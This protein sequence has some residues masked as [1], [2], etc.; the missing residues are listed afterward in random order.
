MSTEELLIADKEYHP[1]D[2]FAALCFERMNSKTPTAG[3]LFP[4][5][6]EMMAELTEKGMS[7]L[8]DQVEMPLA[9]VLFSMESSGFAL[10]R[11]VL[12]HLHEVFSQR[13]AD[14]AEQIYAQAG[15]RFNILSTK[16]LGTILFEKLG[17]PP[18]K[19]NKTGYSTDSDRV[20]RWISIPPAASAIPPP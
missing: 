15:E 18:Q 16:Q 7:F 12:S 17:L 20:S 4:L 2:S 9:D 1:I 11:S 14:L 6:E 19:K 13:Q 5:M 8:Y 3:L 10:D